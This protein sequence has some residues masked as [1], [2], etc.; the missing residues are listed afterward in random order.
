MIKIFPFLAVVALTAC[1]H[2]TFQDVELGMNQEEVVTVAGK[3][4]SVIAAY[5]VDDVSVEIF[6][7]DKGGLWWGDLDKSYWFYFV[8]G[9][10]EKWERP[11]DYFPYVDALEY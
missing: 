2:Q 8:D 6:E 5:N 3:P 9:K 7:Y 4:D 10:L 11:G 1:A